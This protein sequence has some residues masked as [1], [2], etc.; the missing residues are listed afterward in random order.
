MNDPSPLHCLRDRKL[1][2]WAVG[3]LTVAIAV[4]GIMEMAGGQFL[5]DDLSTCTL[6]SDECIEAMEYI[7]KLI[8]VDKVQP[9]PGFEAQGYRQMRLTDPRWA[10]QQD[11]LIVFNDQVFDNIDRTKDRPA[12]PTRQANGFSSA[13][14]DGRNAVQGTRDTS[15]II[16]GKHA[17]PADGDS[18]SSVGPGD[19]A[20]RNRIGPRVSGT[21]R[22]H[23]PATRGS[24]PDQAVTQRRAEQSRLVRDH[25]C[26]VDL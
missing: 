11:A 14:T 1:G 24:I 26:K 9:Y 25:G 8:V 4:A 2:Q 21:V 7:H 15:P 19:L 3:Y 12:N 16:M 22:R 20:A 23:C 5:S 6:D 18:R 10:E 13:V 17:D